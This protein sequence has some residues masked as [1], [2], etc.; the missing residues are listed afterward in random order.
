M[1]TTCSSHTFTCCLQLLLTY[2][3]ARNMIE[4]INTGNRRR[5]QLTHAGQKKKKRTIILLT[6]HPFIRHVPPS[7]LL[8]RAHALVC[9]GCNLIQAEDTATCQIL[10]NLDPHDKS[11]ITVQ[12]ISQDPSCCVG[13]YKEKA[14]ATSPDH[15][16][17][18]PTARTFARWQST[19]CMLRHTGW[20]R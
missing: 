18:W 2:P 8:A 12:I 9:L 13:S 20:Y 3:K 10:I 7:V 1:S 11:D 4:Q 14:W 19:L 6:W 15:H 5:C 17:V 16:G